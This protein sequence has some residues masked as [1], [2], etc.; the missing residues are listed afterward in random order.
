M[1]ESEGKGVWVIRDFV[2]KQGPAATE[3]ARNIQGKFG[4]WVLRSFDRGAE[5]K[6]DV[7]VK[8]TF[9]GC[10]DVIDREALEGTHLKRKTKNR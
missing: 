2:R 1:E 5:T 6:S 4:E 9:R 8:V 7:G 3:T 10:V